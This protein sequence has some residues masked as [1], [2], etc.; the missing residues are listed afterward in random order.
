MVTLPRCSTSIIDA[1]QCNLNP[2]NLV[3]VGREGHELE[4]E[5][6]ARPVT[7]LPGRSSTGLMG[8]REIYPT[9]SRWDLGGMPS[10]SEFC[11]NSEEYPKKGNWHGC[12]CQHGYLSSGG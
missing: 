3:H 1:H 10:D 12:N 5:A 2:P 11:Q 7:S 8:I 9:R 4:L 6:I